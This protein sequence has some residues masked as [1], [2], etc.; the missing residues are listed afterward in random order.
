[1][2]E[3][4]IIFFENHLNK[5]YIYYLE[6]L[7]A[8][9]K[10][11]KNFHLIKDLKTI[12]E[13]IKNVRF[14][15]DVLILGF[16]ATDLNEQNLPDLSKIKIPKA[17]YLNKEYQLLDYKL[18]WIKD[19]NFMRGFTVLD[20]VDEFSN[21]SSTTFLKSS[22]AVNP[23]KFKPKKINYEFD[24]S[25]SGVIRKEQDND[26][27]RKVMNELFKDPI[28]Y[29]KRISFTSHLNNKPSDYLK[30]L[31]KSKVTFSSTG[32]ADIVGTRYFE[33][34]CTGKTIVLSNTKEGVFDNLFED[35]KHFLTFSNVNEIQY[36]YQEFVEN[37]DYFNKILFEAR[38]NVLE[39]HTWEHRA[40]QVL[41][42]IKDNI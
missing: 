18:S 8:I 3:L 1:M 37:E 29:D 14:K 33:A 21:V 36:L 5:K 34:M 2:K 22:F 32:P 15:P 13:D 31:C 25:F 30:N 41:T 24:I 12:H 10:Q 17:I 39:N 20:K 35:K 38:K 19:Q 27:R 26:I 4:N 9:K 42:E 6:T 16:G 11:S 7:N 28:W 23:K 40:T